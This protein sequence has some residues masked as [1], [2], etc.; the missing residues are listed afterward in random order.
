MIATP[1]PRTQPPD[2]VK[3][4]I[5]DA[6]YRLK[7]A[8]GGRLECVKKIRLVIGAEVFEHILKGNVA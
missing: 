8:I 2:L 1:F 6:K 3:V 4:S 5:A 7:L